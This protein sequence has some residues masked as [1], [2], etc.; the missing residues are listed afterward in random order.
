MIVKYC[1]LIAHVN[2]KGSYYDLND[3]EFLLEKKRSLNWFH[4]KS[5]KRQ[6][7]SVSG[8]SVMIGNCWQIL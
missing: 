5:L 2:V 7:M 4:E 6:L 8:L 1:L 3:L